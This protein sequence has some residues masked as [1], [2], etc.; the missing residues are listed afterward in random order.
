MQMNWFIICGGQCSVLTLY[1]PSGSI[2]DYYLTAPGT[3][4]PF[5]FQTVHDSESVSELPRRSLYDEVKSDRDL[6]ESDVWIE[7][8]DLNHLIRLKGIFEGRLVSINV[9]VYLEYLSLR[10]Y[11]TEP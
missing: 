10:S 9:D 3:D 4:P 7:G 1:F 5:W 6:T 2:P 8:R 11:G